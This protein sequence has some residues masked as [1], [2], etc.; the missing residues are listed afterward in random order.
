MKLP[1]LAQS[2]IVVALS[3]AALAVCYA[4]ALRGMFHQWSSD[5]DMSHGFLVPLVIAWIVWRERERW[6]KLPVK[7]SVW[8]CALLAA[9]AAL[10][11][12]SAVGGG[13]FAGSLAFLV[14]VAGVVLCLGG[15]DRL[16]AWSFPLLLSAFMLP[17]LAVV[18]NQATLPLQLLASRLAAFMLTMAGVGVIREGNILDV[19]GH[20]VAVVEACNGIRYLLALAFLALVFG[21]LSD[22]KPW[23]R[24]A[25]LATAIPTAIFAN[26]ARVACAS[27]WPLL[28]SGTPHL[29]AGAVIFLV[30]LICLYAA[31]ELYNAVYWNYHA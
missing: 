13:L 25:L 16:R 28:D 15:W 31:R 12:V 9:A 23:M 27:W 10:H 11:F 20:R 29:L 30:C 19:G 4:P 6:G 8:G 17:K 7:P 3:A 21:Y 26:A 5:E 22:S 1:Q 18:Y 14:S 2:K 24:L